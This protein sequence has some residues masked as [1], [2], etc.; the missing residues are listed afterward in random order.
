MTYYLAPIYTNEDGGMEPGSLIDGVV[1]SC[2]APGIQT[3]YYGN[4][5]V[6]LQSLTGTGLDGWQLL[7]R[8]EAIAAWTT[9]KGAPPPEGI[10]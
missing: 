1:V 6:L 9:E 7:T 2:F 4:T 10:F 3:L 8:D 5:E